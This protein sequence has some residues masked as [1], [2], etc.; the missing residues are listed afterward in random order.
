MKF[1]EIPTKKIGH[2]INY[3]TKEKFMDL[4]MVYN[5]K[6]F[7][8]F[9]AWIFPHKTYTSIGALINYDLKN[10]YEFRNMF[11]SEFRDIFDVKK[12]KIE[13]A[14]IN[15][16]YR[17]VEFGNMFLVGDAAGLASGW[18]GEGIYPALVSSEEVAKNII[19]KN[20]GYKKLKRWVKL[21]KRHEF[22]VKLV[23]NRFLRDLIYCLFLTGLK[24]KKIVKIISKTL[25]R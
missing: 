6:K 2:C 20:S 23:K 14:L 24:N 21:R 13:S 12:A 3:V 9:Y 16:D 1:L 10:A 19:N 7:G 4:E 11:E 22:F 8:G 5:Y 17:G 25:N 18:T 15:Y